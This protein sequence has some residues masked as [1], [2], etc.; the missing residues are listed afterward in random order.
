MITPDMAIDAPSRVCGTGTG[1]TLELTDFSAENGIALW[2]GPM[3]GTIGGGADL[4]SQFEFYGETAPSLAG[5]FDLTAGNQSNYSTCAICV[6]AFA[7]D[8]NGE[9]TKQFFQSG[10]SVT[11][12]ED[13]FTNAHMKAMFTNLELEEVT[14]APMTY[15]S[16]PVEGGECADFGNFMVDR[17]RVPN[18]WTCPHADY[19]T[20]MA[21]GTQCNCMCGLADPDCYIPNTPVAGCATA[22][23]ACFN[24]ACVVPPTNDTCATATALTIGTPVNGTTAGAGYNYSAGLDGQQC[25]KY[26]Q[27]GPD[28]AYSVVLAANQAITVTLS[29]LDAQYDG[30]VALVGPG[31]AATVCDVN[32]IATCVAGKDAA[33]NGGTETFTYTATTAGT[34]YLIVDGYTPAEGGTFTLNV[35]SP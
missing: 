6:R 1:G 26:L 24:D 12:T 29:N 14:V 33:G 23:N 28:V 13:P 11:L 35:T 3:T 34:Y 15:V 16:T 30:S 31:T 20:G 21:T 9:V 22:G 19:D 32:P 5:T 2:S 17:D 7:L 8:A 27:P 4:V 18:A 25:T 10:G